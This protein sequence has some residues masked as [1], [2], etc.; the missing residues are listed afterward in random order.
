MATRTGK[1]IGDIDPSRREALNAGTIESATLSECLIVDFAALMQ[2]AFPEISEKAVPRLEQASASGITRRMALAGKLLADWLGIAALSAVREHP[3]DTVRGWLCFMIGE[4]PTLSLPE[5]LAAMLPLADDP[6]FGVREW[7]WLALRPHIAADLD[8]AISL[9][10]PWT[11]SSS[12]FIRR[13]ACEAIRPRGVWCAHLP[14]LKQQPEKGLPILEPLKADPAVYVQDS[15][16]NWLNDA[17][18]DKPDWVR[19]V[20]A[21]WLEESDCPAT[22]RICKRAL[23]S[24]AKA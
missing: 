4:T 22:R 11:A 24:L 21:R 1:R 16:A 10:V 5:R 18:K 23:R 20:C 3:S 15:V 13:F 6:H 14:A 12:A 9:L 17:A 8:A 7:S 19:A 2:A